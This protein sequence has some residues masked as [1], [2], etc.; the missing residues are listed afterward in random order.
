MGTPDFAAYALKKLYEAGQEI[1]CVVTQPDKPKGRSGKLVCSPVKEFAL[2]KNLP[3]YQPEKIKA[4][5]SVAYL[6]NIEADLYVVAA[7]GQ[8]L[9]QEV[10]TDWSTPSLHPMRCLLSWA[11]EMVMLLSSWERW[12]TC[13]ISRSSK[14]TCLNGCPFGEA[15]TSSSSARFS[16]LPTHA[17]ASGSLSCSSSSERSCRRSHFLRISQEK[18]RLK[19]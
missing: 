14:L 7:F 3:V 16:T 11:G 18:T 8:I 17:S 13:S 4:A 15:T 5:D 12:S 19:T 2:E 9:S 6:K 1:V 10:S